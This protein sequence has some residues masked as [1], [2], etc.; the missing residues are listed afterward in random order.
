VVTVSAL[1]VYESSF[2]NTEAVA[3]AVAD[4]IAQHMP[5]RVVAV[6]DPRAEASD[7]ETLVVVGGPTHAFGMSRESTRREAQGRGGHAS[8]VETGV[9]DWV[10]RLPADRADRLYATFD[11]RV[12]KVQHLP[13]SAARAAARALHRSGHHA[14]GHPESFFVADVEGPLL[15]DELGR[16][17]DWGAALAGAATSIWAET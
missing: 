2:G 12:A 14:V 17:R 13:G 5:V 16:A 3:R 8:Q 11:T 6:A 10:A 15:P 7:D 4:G 1:V 9:R